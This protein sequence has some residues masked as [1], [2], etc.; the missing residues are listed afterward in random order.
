VPELLRAFDGFALSS[1]YEGMP[2]VFPQAMAARLPIVAT[3]VDGAVEAITPGE[4]GWLVDVGDIDGL[5]ERLLQVASDR[6][7][8]RRMGERGLERVT[9]FS[10][11]GMVSQLETLYTRLAVTKGL[12]PKSAEEPTRGLGER[13]PGQAA[14]RGA[15][16]GTERASA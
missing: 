15:G 13:A 14:P 9:E 10:A 7:Q 12:L 3:R 16:S 6:E 5:A 8:A 4:N 2:R 11:R 1:L